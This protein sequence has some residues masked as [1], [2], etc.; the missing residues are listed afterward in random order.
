MKQKEVKR[1]VKQERRA[2]PKF[3]IPKVGLSM[4]GSGIGGIQISRQ[5]FN[6]SDSLS[7]SA[8]NASEVDQPPRAIRSFLPEYPYLARRDNITGRIVL[9]FVVDVDG[10]A[11]EAEVIRAE[12]PEVLEIFSNQALKALKR[13]R[14]K[15]AVKD[16]K[17]VLCTA[18]LGI[19]F[20]L[21]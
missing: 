5:D 12:P 9:K 2:Q 10:L 8:Y 6:I 14:F 15:P 21:E 7:M 20:N 4:S 18:I 11:K 1:E 16:G 3:D 13:Y 19:S 17:D